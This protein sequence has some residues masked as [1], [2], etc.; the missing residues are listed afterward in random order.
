MLF[1]VHDKGLKLGIYED[2]GT[3]TCGGYPGSE[4]DLQ[5]DADTFA[6]WDIDSLKFDGCNSD[7]KDMPYGMFTEIYMY[8]MNCFLFEFMAYMNATGITGKRNKAC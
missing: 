1:K 5:Q 8:I 2:F 4:F 6:S 3:T 7:V